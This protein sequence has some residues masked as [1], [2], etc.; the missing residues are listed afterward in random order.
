MKTID[1]R[2]LIKKFKDKAN[3]NSSPSG[4]L[5]GAVSL[6]RSVGTLCFA[7]VLCTVSLSCNEDTKI[8]PAPTPSTPAVEAR[9]YELIYTPAKSSFSVWAP[10]AE[11]VALTFY[12]EGSGGIPIKTVSMKKTDGGYWDWEEFGDLKGKFYTFKIWFEGKFLAETPGIWA[13]A[14]GVNGNRA[15]VVDMA[16]TNPDGWEQD[17]RPPLENFTD[18]V[19]YEMHHRDFSIEPN[20]G[21]VNKGKYLALTETGTKSIDGLSTGIDHLKELGVTHIHLLPS[22]DFASIDE[23]RLDL[24]VY[25]WGYDPK[26]FNVPDGSF[27]TNPHDPVV[28]IKEFKQMV[29]SLHNNGFRVILDVVYNHTSSASSSPFALTVPNYFYRYTSDGKLSNGSGCGNETASEKEAM[30]R[31]I[32]ESVKYWAKEYRID[33]FRFDLMGLHDI[34]TMNRVRA[35]LDLIDPTIF[36]YGEGWIVGSSTLPA[37]QQSLKS[38]GL[39][40]PGIAVFSD[41]LRNAIRGS[42]S[43]V[44]GFAVGV[45]GQDQMLKFGICGATQNVSK[46]PYANNPDEVIN[47]VTCHDNR[48]LFDRLTATA[49]KDATAD[50]L[51]RFNLLAQTIV[52]TS[53][54]VPFIFAGEELYRTKKG[55]DNSYKSPD[56]VN[57][58]LWENKKTYSRVFEYY[59]NLIALRKAHPAFRMTTKED[60][61]KNLKFLTTDSSRRV[62]FTLDGNAVND[63]WGNIVVVFNGDRND[64]PFTLPEG[65]W[66]VVCDD[67]AI[68]LDSQTQVSGNIMLKASSAFIA[69]K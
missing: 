5:G 45:S 34:E 18:I 41:D 30:S 4:R 60:V 69:Y 66:T 49:P 6:G 47:Y 35:E 61:A 28:R 8:K 37:S 7:V 63:S 24:N 38:N 31:Y 33:G 64:A 29:Q 67:A 53:Q 58:I 22:F 48:C 19:I 54:G 55:I 32:V 20:S 1:L 23:A 59:R 44:A 13:K 27:S 9:N 50:E 11:D 65:N 16:D 51:I 12:T 10:T 15:M 62:A 14:V 26:N 57:Q 21:M 46:S 25:N 68:N 36:L 3:F 39:K 2:T 42:S 40:F 52:F 56:D 43:S 17:T